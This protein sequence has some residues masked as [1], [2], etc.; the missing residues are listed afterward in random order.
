MKLLV[1]VTS[2]A[3]SLILTQS[4]FAKQRISYRTQARRIVNFIFPP[5]TRDIM[6]RVAGCETGYTYNPHA[7]NRSGATGY[8]QILSS[9]RGTTYSYNGISITVDDK[10]LFNPVYNTMV[11]Y[12]MSQGGKNLDAWYASRSC[13]AA[14]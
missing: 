3:L 2:L 10:K 1:L 6:F 7:Y 8:F 5:E 12:L 13:W 4:S 9:H 11:A 14:A